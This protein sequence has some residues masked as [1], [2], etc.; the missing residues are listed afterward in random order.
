MLNQFILTGILREYKKSKDSTSVIL[1]IQMDPNDSESLWAVLCN[2]DLPFIPTLN[3]Y[4]NNTLG[5]KGYISSTS[6][7]KMTC[8]ATSITIVGQEVL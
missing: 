4:L 6:Q 3:K 2:K 7:G 1:I 8:V 5:L